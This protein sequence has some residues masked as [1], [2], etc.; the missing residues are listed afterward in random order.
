[1]ALVTAQQ[2]QQ[3]SVLGAVQQG[4][5]NRQF[6]Q[7]EAR[8][9]QADA[10]RQRL[11]QL[12]EEQAAQQ[13]FE[14][15]QQL[16]TLQKG[17]GLP[18]QE[19][20]ADTQ[21][22]AIIRTFTENPEQAKKVLDDVGIFDER[23]REAAAAFADVA[24]GAQ[25]EEEQFF[26]IDEQARKVGVEGGDTVEILR[27][28][29]MPVQERTIALKTLKAAALTAQQRAILR[30]QRQESL[31]KQTSRLRG[32]LAKIKGESDEK[33]FNR[34]QKL[35]KEFISSAGEFVKTRDSFARVQASASDPSAAGDLALIFN[36]MKVLDP[37]SVVR[38]SEFATAQ[39]AAGI[40]ERVRAQF[41]RLQEG[42]RLTPK[43][44]KDF[45]TR[46]GKLFNKQVNS[47]GKRVNEF[48]RLSKEFNVPSSG[49]IVDLTDP[50][51][52]QEAG[53]TDTQ[54]TEPSQ[55]DLTPDEQAELAELKKRFGR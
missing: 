34:S 32:E 44:R 51:T 18:Q 52:L 12:A 45:V 43:T 15:G 39:N 54:Q 50:A 4:L 6:I 40:P 21:E 13:Q 55:G 17:F 41:N 46:A 5:Q 10:N 3:P 8:L 28:K 11:Q 42:E 35:R 31:S 49:V 26:A 30:A 1:M 25:T 14:Q 38:E 16:E 22:Q 37:G 29:E 48:K 9:S 7:Q 24:L 23:Q 53:L 33:T 2:F 20:G 27:L 36:F 47:H 19:R